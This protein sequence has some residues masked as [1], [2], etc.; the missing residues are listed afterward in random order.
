MQIKKQLNEDFENLCEWFVDNKFS[1]HFGDNKTKSTIF[2]SK[3]RAKNIHYL[4]I[5][6]KDIHIEHL[7][8]TYLGCVLDEMMSGESM[9]SK[10]INKMNS[11]LKFLYRKNRFLSPKL[12]RML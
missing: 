9:A 1:I 4:Y 10:V 5:K 3:R 11:I 8:E 12:R 2:A 7:E 6:L